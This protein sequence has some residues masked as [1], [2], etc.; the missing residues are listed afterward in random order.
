MLR[1]LLRDW[2]D[3]E[4]KQDLRTREISKGRNPGTPNSALKGCGV[5]LLK[6]VS[7]F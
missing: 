4:A 1:M 7:Y 6:P 2:P 5:A 3:L